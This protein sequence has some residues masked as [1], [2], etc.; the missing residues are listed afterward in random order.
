MADGLR[1]TGGRRLDDPADFVRLEIEAAL[2]RDIP[3]IPVLV[4]NVSPPKA[5]QLPESLGSLAYRQAIPIRPP[6][7]FQH[8]VERLIRDVERQENNQERLREEE[9][10][11][12][13]REEAGQTEARRKPAIPATPESTSPFRNEPSVTHSARQ[14]DH[15]TP[16][17]QTAPRRTF[18][19][20]RAIGAM[21]VEPLP[22]DEL[23]AGITATETD[24]SDNPYASPIAARAETGSPRVAVRIKKLFAGLVVAVAL[25]FL[26]FRRSRCCSWDG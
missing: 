24:V 23:L 18:P 3:V 22:R 14:S 16:K 17:Q 1:S 9:R 15:A 13:L 8:D 26:F 7:D 5:D 12:R 11:H 21:A 4:D 19:A 6:P 2:K 10:L 20:E 25:S